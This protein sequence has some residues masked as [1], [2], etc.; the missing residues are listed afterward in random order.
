MFNLVLNNL[1]RHVLI[2]RNED[3]KL[4]QYVIGVDGGGTKTSALLVEETGRIIGS[5][6]VGPTNLQ[7]VGPDKLREELLM[8]FDKVTVLLPEGKP[9]PDAICLGLAGAGRPDD[10]EQVRKI[11]E[12]L[13]PNTKIV[14][15]NDG[16]IALE[17]AH[18]GKPGIIIAAGTGSVAFGKNRKD[19]ITRAGGW[20]YLL[21]DEGSAYWIGREAVT[22]SLKAHDGLIPKTI[23]GDRIRSYLGLTSLEGVIRRIYLQGMDHKEIA[24][25][26]PLVFE[27]VREKDPVA[28]TIV[29]EAGQYLSLLAVAVARK[30][31][32][33]SHVRI[34][35]S[36]GLFN[37]K[38][39]LAQY[40]E[41]SLREK[42]PGSEI[43]PCRF[44]PEIGA[45]IIALK[46]L[47][48]RLT[49]FRLCQF[50]SPR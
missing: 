12:G 10:Q 43:V 32:M 22:R 2:S 35:L 30:L 6:K 28:R 40:V 26:A 33:K 25:L 36:G 34:A 9:K 31:R 48:I 29:A 17:G 11:V 3:G 50:Q 23:L 21:G 45:V 5:A 4:M 15:T 49:D 8:I 20:G 27:A 1:L 38:N 39:V 7:I 47:G 16:I 42:F 14:V 41:Q 18:A 13:V 19:K 24:K 44:T 37:E 46:T